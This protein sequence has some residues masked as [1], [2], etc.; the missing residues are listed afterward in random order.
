[1][2]LLLVAPVGTGGGAVALVLVALVAL[3]VV[4]GWFNRQL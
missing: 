1:V 2:L 3:Q 4:R